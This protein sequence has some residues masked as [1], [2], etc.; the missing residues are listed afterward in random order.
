MKKGF[1]PVSPE[2]KFAVKVRNKPKRLGVEGDEF[3]W[4]NSGELGACVE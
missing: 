4:K 2:L 1:E 3:E